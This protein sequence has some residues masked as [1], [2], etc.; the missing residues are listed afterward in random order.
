M[1]QIASFHNLKVGMLCS[2]RPGKDRQ[3][4][5][6]GSVITVTPEVPD[7]ILLSELGYLWTYE[8]VAGGTRDGFGGAVGIFKS[9]TTGHTVRGI[10]P[11]RFEVLEAQENKEGA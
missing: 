3:V 5:R 1:K 10:Y 8:G 4:G 11:N 2:L 7:V 6:N 9:V